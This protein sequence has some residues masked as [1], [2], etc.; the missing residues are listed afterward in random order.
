MLTSHSIFF[1][2]KNSLKP[3]IILDSKFYHIIIY[4]LILIGLNV[5]SLT[6]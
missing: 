5:Y 3:V 4:D 1:F 2:N 6:S